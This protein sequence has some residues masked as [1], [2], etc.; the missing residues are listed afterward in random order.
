MFD[1]G[2][3]VT[4]AEDAVCHAVGVEFGEVFH[5]FAFTNVFDG[6]AG[7]GAHGEGGSA[8]CVTIELGEDE[9]GDADFFIKGLCDADG[10]LSGGGVGNEEGFSGF[11]EFVEI[12]EFAEE[13]GVEFLATCGVED[14]DGAVLVFAP[15]EGVFGNFDEIFF[16][17]FW[18]VAGD[19][20]LLG[21][22][23]ELVDRGGA[24]KVE[25]DEEGACLLYTS[26]SPRD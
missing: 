2:N 7:D 23:G 25:C 19:F 3:D 24:V 13:L 18:G 17:R 11:E 4:H 8:S 15:L 16:V 6:L 14:D 9:A 20:D 1:H 26:P 5:F 21:E 12:F 22:F 10:L